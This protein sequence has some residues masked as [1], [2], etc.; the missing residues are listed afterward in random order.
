M[1]ILPVVGS[2]LSMSVAVSAAET[3]SGVELIYKEIEENTDPYTVTY[4]VTDNHIRIDDDS[5]SSGYIVY[6]IKANKIFSVSHYDKSILVIPEYPHEDYVPEFE[7]KVEYEALENAPKILQKQVYNYR[8]TAVT[9]MTNETCMDIQLVPGLLPDVAKSLQNFQK[10]VSSHQIIG[11]ESTP[12]EFRTPCYLVD[13]IHNKGDYYSKGL[14]IQEWHSNERQR[15]LIN[16]E[17]REMDTAI[18]DIPA[19]YRQ[20][21]LK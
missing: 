3:V 14:P 12:D 6:D 18:F 15:Q 16:F 13:Q 21:S 9:T 11:L 5:D 10:I 1:R 4:K 7:V 8:V 2:L 17:N 20:Y 19:D